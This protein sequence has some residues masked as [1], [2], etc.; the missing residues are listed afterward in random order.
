MIV[1]AN[2]IIIIMYIKI[3]VFICTHKFTIGSKF[4]FLLA[5]YCLRF[6][7]NLQITWEAI[8]ILIML[9]IIIVGSISFFE[10]K[11]DIM[12]KKLTKKQT[13]VFKDLMHTISIYFYVEVNYQFY[14]SLYFVNNESN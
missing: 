11:D 14:I 6:K 9:F 10:N 8:I 13:N 5:D 12:L 4:T 7:P 2:E 1:S 3:I